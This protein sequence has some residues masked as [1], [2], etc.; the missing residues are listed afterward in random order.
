MNGPHDL[1]GLHGLGPVAPERNEPLFH[2]AWERR[3][4]AL[5][6][7]MGARGDWTIDM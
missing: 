1:G 3:V 2:Q 4:F 7:A 6:L 5:T